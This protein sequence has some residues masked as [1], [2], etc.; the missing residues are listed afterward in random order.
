[1]PPVSHRSTPAFRWFLVLFISLGFVL[2]TFWFLLNQRYSPEIYVARPIVSVTVESAWFGGA[3]VAGVCALAM[4]SRR[5][6]AWRSLARGALPLVVI[7]L[8]VCA[9]TFL[10]FPIRTY[11]M[12]LFGIACGWTTLLWLRQKDWLLSGRAVSVLR[13]G[14]WS[15]VALLF[16]YQFW[17]QVGYWNNLALGYADCGESAR[18]MFNTM[19]NPCEL[20]LRANPDK[21]LFYD[22]FCPG[23]LP[24][25]PLWLLW[26]SL[27]LTIVLQLVAVFGVV[28]PLYYI[29]QHAFR[30]AT[31]ALLL[32]LVWLA[33]PSTSQFIYSA[34]YGFRWGNLCLPLYFT[35]LAFWLNGRSGW[36]LAMVIWAMLIKEEAAIITGMFGL[37]LALFERRQI[38]GTALAVFAFGY[39]F[40]STS[41]LVPAISGQAYAMTRF[42]YDLG[43][44][45]WEILLSPITKPPV[46]WGRL[47]EPSSLYFGAALVGP[48]LFLPMRKPSVLFVGVLTFVFCCLHP[49]MKSITT[50]YQATLLPVVFWALVRAVQ[51]GEPQRRNGTL[52]SVAITGVVFSIFLGAQPW[53]KTTL[54]VHESPGR[55][56]LVRR[57]GEQIDP[58]GALMAT[59]RVAAHFITQRYLYLDPP[60]PDRVDYALL[61][62]RDFW[63]GGAGAIDWLQTH[64]DL[65]HKV[66]ANPHLHLVDANDGLLLY[67]RHGL[68]L[69]RQKLVERDD[70]PAAANRRQVD[71]GNGVRIAGFIVTPLPRAPGDKLDRVRVTTFSTIAANANVDLAV[72]CVIHEGSDPAKEETYVSEFQPLGQGIWPIARWETNK[73]YADDFIV[74]LPAEPAGEI[75]SVSFVAATLSP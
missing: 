37:Y 11:D 69:D 68:P 63:R 29:G 42:F 59:Q 61:D 65:Q 7:S 18:V 62:L 9:K 53:S 12:M 71:L 16:A 17:R 32:V 23:L 19:T 35:A 3:L 43:H 55:L 20:F 45:K 39:F 41:I 14:V 36:A 33:Y 57:F 47:F 8:L 1:M 50:W 21:P 70:L 46:F 31:P 34:S 51:Q 73:C 28:V 66:E 27:K 6:D 49:M 75:S 60:V 72:C 22:H 56:D 54:T 40:L 26:P 25:M 38:T 10:G 44:T 13:A 52:V 4:L 58:R 48:L 30:N 2:N 74:T 15:A 24:F 67:S 5:P 64:R